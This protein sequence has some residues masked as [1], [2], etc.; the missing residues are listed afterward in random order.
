MNFEGAFLSY[1]QVFAFSYVKC[2][3]TLKEGKCELKE[4]KKSQQKEGK[5]RAKGKQVGLRGTM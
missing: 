3:G 2:S 5:K 4:G 1:F